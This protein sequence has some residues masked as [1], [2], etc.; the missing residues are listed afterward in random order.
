MDRLQLEASNKPGVEHDLVPAIYSVA[1]LFR[2]AAQELLSDALPLYRYI[3]VG[4]GGWNQKLWE[5]LCGAFGARSEVAPMRSGVH[6]IARVRPPLWEECHNSP[7][8]FTYGALCW[9]QWRGAS[10]DRQV[11]LERLREYLFA[12][13]N[14]SQ[15]GQAAV[16]AAL[17]RPVWPSA[18]LREAVRCDSILCSPSLRLPLDSRVYDEQAELAEVVLK[19]RSDRQPRLLLY[20]SPPSGGKTSSVALAATLLTAERAESEVY[21]IYACRSPCVQ[22]HL[23]LHLRAGGVQ[24]ARARNLDDNSALHIEG[25]GGAAEVT[26]PTLAAFLD[27]WPEHL[28]L[29]PLVLV[30]DVDAAV[31]VCE[32]RAN[33]ALFLDEACLATGSEEERQALLA[34]A[35]QFLVLMSS[36]LPDRPWIE[37]CVRSHRRIW[38]ALQCLY[39][40]SRR[41]LQSVTAR[42]PDGSVIMPHHFRVPVQ[43][44][45]QQQ[46]LARF[47]SAAALEAILKE[48]SLDADAV[49]EA[50]DV[51][52]HKAIRR[53]CLELIAEGAA[54]AR[55]KN[56]VE[57]F[58]PWSFRAWELALDVK[59]L[60]LIYT[61]DV[62]ECLSTGRAVWSK[63][64]GGC[65][66][67]PCGATPLL[68]EA[69]LYG[70][71]AFLGQPRGALYAYE[72][73]ACSQ[74]LRG[75]A[76][77]AVLGRETIYGVHW[78]VLRIV[79]RDV[80]ESYEAATHLCGRTA[81]K[82]SSQEASV[83]FRSEADAEKAMAPPASYSAGDALQ[84]L[85]AGSS[86]G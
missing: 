13:C 68:E 49:L 82:N 84:I 37:S 61:D 23:C 69:A 16:I 40:T 54:A 36:T 83:F 66:P 55:A 9:A 12:R 25:P 79:M 81:R 32:C 27:S 43:V 6:A 77:C 44:L 60:S 53:K 56:D 8:L 39:V 11:S 2:L 31:A 70:V 74:A 78:P 28:G 85:P 33:D 22:A 64:P 46:H 76:R 14:N 17:R 18:L 21:L 50:K 29:R 42:L 41:L 15:S 67:V 86:R 10:L 80:P 62:F 65:A 57:S 20:Q 48:N 35:P 47:Y 63:L 30:C 59:G 38:P 7:E 52:S 72:R 34:K 19:W 1:R 3:N 4:C 71:L 73:W 24:Y 51:L 58:E 45:R 5:Q 75:A 26:R